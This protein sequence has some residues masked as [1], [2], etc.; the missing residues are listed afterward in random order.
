MSAP[1]ITPRVVANDECDG[2]EFT[3]STVYS[4]SDISSSL[5]TTATVRL[6]YSSLGTY[7][8]YVFTVVSNVITA[9][10]LQATENPADATNISSYIGDGISN[11]FP[12]VDFDLSGDYGVTIP[13]V[14]DGVYYTSYRVQ[15]LNE[16]DAPFDY[17]GTEEVI[18]SCSLCCCVA[19]K[20]A[21]INPDCG[22]EDKD[23]LVATRA[24]GYMMAARYAGDVGNIDN[25]VASLNIGTTI[26]DNNDC[27]CS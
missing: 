14:Q 22:C 26:C 9:V 1:A 13:T 7:I 19:N 4:G 21:S 5:V 11:V 23:L 24:W 15:G 10:T 25:A 8:E 16:A 20:F 6:N 18:I 27:G 17:S 12:L 3:D 2:L